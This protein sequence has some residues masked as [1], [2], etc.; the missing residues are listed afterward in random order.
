MLHILYK[1]SSNKQLDLTEIEKKVINIIKENQK[2]TI[3]ECSIKINKSLRITKN[4]F[5]NLKEKNILKRIG[6]RKTGYWEV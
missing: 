3:E 2:I 5:K 6:S 1:E 4:I